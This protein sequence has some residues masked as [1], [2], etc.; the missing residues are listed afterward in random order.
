MEYPLENDKKYV[1][2]FKNLI[3]SVDYKPKRPGA[4]DAGEE[5]NS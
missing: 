2:F 4:S 3:L 1:R 5:A